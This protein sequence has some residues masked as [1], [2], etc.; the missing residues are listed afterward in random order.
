MSQ[1]DF[2]NECG[3]VGGKNPYRFFK[4]FETTKFDARKFNKAFIDDP[5]LRFAL[6]DST[7]PILHQQLS[8]VEEGQDTVNLG[9]VELFE[10]LEASQEGEDFT[11]NEHTLQL[12]EIIKRN[13]QRIIT[14]AS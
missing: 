14:S 13:Q 9:I 4:G 12:E 5:K 7:I 2:A 11:P 10:R 6:Y 8:R 3:L 1:Y